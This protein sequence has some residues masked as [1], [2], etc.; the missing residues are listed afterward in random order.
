MENKTKMIA[1]F[2]GHVYN[3]SEPDK[4]F[5]SYTKQIEIWK[6][7]FYQTNIKKF[8]D[9]YLCLMWNNYSENLLSQPP[10]TNF[11]ILINAL[12]WFNEQE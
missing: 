9:L 4:Y 6:R 11:L 7:L 12:E 3:P 1:D 2:M 10:E 8:N 5:S